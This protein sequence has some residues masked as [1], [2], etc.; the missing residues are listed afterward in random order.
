MKG[1]SSGDLAGKRHC[2][3]IPQRPSNKICYHE[4]AALAN[5]SSSRNAF[6][7]FLISFTVL[8]SIVHKISYKTCFI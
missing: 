6:N 5:G 3:R 8:V 7:I 1:V 2:P 4:H